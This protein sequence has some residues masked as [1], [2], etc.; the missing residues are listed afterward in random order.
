M[1]TFYCPECGTK[2]S[3]WENQSPIGKKKRCKGCHEFFLLQE[4]TMNPPTSQTKSDSEI[5]GSIPPQTSQRRESSSLNLLGESEIMAHFEQRAG[6]PEDLPLDLEESREVSQQRQKTAQEKA[7]IKKTPP[8]QSP[9]PPTR[10]KRPSQ[11]PSQRP[12]LE[13]KDRSKVKKK[14]RMT[15]GSVFMLFFSLLIGLQAGYILYRNPQ[16]IEIT[17]Q[18]FIQNPPDT[19]WV[20]ITHCYL[21]YDEMAH[22]ESKKGE[23]SAIYVPVKAG[24]YAKEYTI[25]LEV[26]E[27]SFIEFYKSRNNPLL[28]SQN[29]EEYQKWE[30]LRGFEGY[31][32]IKVLQDPGLKSE[33]SQFIGNFH[34]NF[35]MIHY[36]QMPHIP[37]CIL[38]ILLTFLLAIKAVSSWF[39]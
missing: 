28:Y 31:V 6:E 17:Y 3:F 30:S 29:Q 24:P 14:I 1:L 19:E 18:D 25:L 26:V 12:S 37:F 22:Y 32:I 2:T 35:T 16:P 27:E 5:I 34:E 11:R 36:G 10:P 4:S 39:I 20:K 7:K 13:K 33:V 8:A 21:D 9:S 15:Y 38:L 23:I